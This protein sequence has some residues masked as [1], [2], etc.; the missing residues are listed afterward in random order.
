MNRSM[1]SRAPFTDWLRRASWLAA[2]LVLAA[3]MTTPSSSAPTIIKSPN[4]N[5]EFRAVTLANGLI[6]VLVSDP[7]SE[8]SAA[9]LTVFR[10]SYDDPKNRLG[11]AHFLEH[12]LFLGTAKY[13]NVDDYQKFITTH[14]GTFNAYTASD[15]TNFFFDIQ[16][17]YFDGGL[18]RFAQFFI[19]PTFDEKY[20]DRE[21]NAVNSEYQLYFKDDDWRS[22]AVEKQEMNPAHPGSNFSV[23]SLATLAGDVRTDLIE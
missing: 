6:A 14:G 19:A 8:K 13:P 16:P 4:D 23:G 5:R 20:V 9:A 7:T 21:K 18:D 11:L 10:G 17:A 22:S 2:A 12:M 15:H 3:C 1:L